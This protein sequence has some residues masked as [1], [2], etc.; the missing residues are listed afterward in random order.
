MAKVLASDV[1]DILETQEEEGPSN[2]EQ[3]KFAND[4]HTA[5]LRLAQSSPRQIH[6]CCQTYVE[7]A[8]WLKS[9]KTAKEHRDGEEILK[10]HRKIRKHQF[11][12]LTELNLSDEAIALAEKYDD[13]EAL[14]DI[15]EQ[16]SLN[17]HDIEPSLPVR[18]NQYFDKFGTQWANEYFSRSLKDGK[19]AVETLNNNSNY[20]KF[21]TDFL[22]SHSGYANVTW[23]NEV[24]TER[25][26]FSASTYLEQSAKHTD[27]LWS[28]KVMLS[29]G[30]LSVQAAEGK[31]Q[32][33]QYAAGPMIQ[34]LDQHVTLLKMQDSLHDFFKP[35][36]KTAIDS[37]AAV[38]VVMENFGK[39]SVEGKPLLKQQL[40]SNLSHL[41]GRVTIRSSDLINVLT[42]MDNDTE[43]GVTNHFL[44]HR[45]F[46]SLNI[47]RLLSAIS[48]I[49]LSSPA[50][51]LRSSMIW[52]RILI[53]SDWTE[54]NRTELKNDDQVTSET[55]TTP[56][57]QTLLEGHRN[58]YGTEE[59]E[60]FWDILPPPRTPSEL[61]SAGTDPAELRSLPE[62]A[63][64]SD[65]ILVK[66]ARE[67]RGE[68]KI[69]ER[70]IE[71]G[72]LEEWYKGVL[73]AAGSSYRDEIDQQGEE[74]AEK[75]RLSSTFIHDMTRQDR[76]KYLL[77]GT[78]PEGD[79]YEAV[80]TAFADMLSNPSFIL[81][82]T[83]AWFFTTGLTAP[84]TQDG[85][86]STSTRALGNIPEQ[87]DYVADFAP[88]GTRLEPLDVLIDGNR[89]IAELALEDTI[90]L[91]QPSSFDWQGVRISVAGHWD[92]TRTI[93]RQ[94]AIWGIFGALLYME[95]T[96]KYVEGDLR[97][98]WKGQDVGFVRIDRV[99]A[100][101][102][103][104]D[105]SAAG[106]TG[107]PT[108]EQLTTSAAELNSSGAVGSR[109]YSWAESWN[110]PEV[111]DAAYFI[112]LATVM[113]LISPYKQ[114]TVPEANATGG[115]GTS[116]ITV[117]DLHNPELVEEFMS[118]YWMVLMCARAT[119][120]GAWHVPRKR[121]DL[122]LQWSEGSRVI[123]NWGLRYEASTAAGTNTLGVGPATA[124]GT[125][126]VLSS[127]VVATS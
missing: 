13:M 82:S 68:A 20:K 81:V 120:L 52:R 16:E 31:D 123:A 70:H 29:L 101:S 58:R 79:T 98:Q 36:I 19:I 100:S 44:H 41:F 4:I 1:D 17:G 73:E 90:Q 6:M 45:F 115:F 86:L 75:V 97:L 48:H 54:F 50:S 38:D 3:E 91:M 51:S 76:E 18:I 102:A 60:S 21:L 122:K 92:L 62:Y 24:A 80:V 42:V 56:L 65:S 127:S 8:R 113:V 126:S 5:M 55:R 64:Q 35:Y 34:R 88:D 106:T 7:R 28:Q 43:Q 124:T 95:E 61:L 33:R 111:P 22:R 83:A 30:K 23:I 109:Q 69:L 71:K 9:R 72:R 99:L 78:I 47:A 25:D 85:S 74:E 117:G 119:G 112:P 49:P 10:I 40:R 94:Y 108:V 57:F 93:V 12:D 116:Q 2:E 121:L 110:D 67:L 77:H 87:F 59:E 27:D 66:L 32:T 104:R 103:K 107:L 125:S 89:A 63:T 26:Y 14:L 37:E 53:S 11:V 15:L 39:R 105:Y 118:Y 96:Q 46:L 84:T 114:N